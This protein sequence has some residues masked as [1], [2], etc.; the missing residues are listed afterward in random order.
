[1]LENYEFTHKHNILKL[2]EE[3]KECVDIDSLRN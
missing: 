2:C 1:M 3:E